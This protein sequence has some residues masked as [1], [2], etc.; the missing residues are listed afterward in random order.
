MKFNPTPVQG[1]YTIELNKIDDERGFFARAFCCREFVEQGLATKFLQIN[2]S[3]SVQ[4]GTLR[5]MHYQLQPNAETKLVR[6]IKGALYDVVLDLREDSSTFGQS[7]GVDITSDN[8]RM[9]YIPKGCAHGFIT[10]A[11]D[12]EAFYFV[13]AFYAPDHE[14]GIRFDDPRFAISWPA[15]PTVV[16]DKD[17]SHRDFDPA[18]HLGDADKAVVAP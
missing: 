15:A 6:C 14:R 10:L 4:K 13:D 12:T 17:R 5:G 1:A 18:Y 2:N 11:D 16:S 8:R 3:L 7:Y 9:M